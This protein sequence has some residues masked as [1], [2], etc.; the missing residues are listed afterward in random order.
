MKKMGNE[1]KDVSKNEGANASVWLK[2]VIAV[3]IAVVVFIALIVE[4]L[5]FAS[6]V[7]LTTSVVI[8]QQTGIS[9]TPGLTF[10]EFSVQDMT[11]LIMSWFLPSLFLVLLMAALQ[12]K[13]WKVSCH[14]LWKLLRRAFR[15]E[16][17]V[18]S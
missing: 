15:K 4:T 6:T 2:R 3:A 18:N 12:I 14:G 1:A 5:A 11:V 13:L 9:I 8:F 17:N 7:I 16:T 10:S